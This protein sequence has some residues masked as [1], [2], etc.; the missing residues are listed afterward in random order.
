[1]PLGDKHDMR[2]GILG[3]TF[4]PVHYGHLLMAESC[5]EQLKLEQVWFMPAAVPPH[6][7]Q[8]DVTPAAQRI[9]MLELAIGG[10]GAF[11]VCPYE[12]EKGS[13]SYTV[14]TLSYLV[15]EDPSREIFFILGADSLRDLPSWRQPERICHLAV[16]AV[17]SRSLPGTVDTGEELDFGPLAR[18]VS[19][20]R[21]DTIRSHQVRMPR[22]DLSSSDIR[23]RVA[24]ARSI[25]YQTPRAVEKY[26]DAERLY[27]G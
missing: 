5:R 1:M 15:E 13:V 3:G 17:V 7:Q 18:L 8:A 25:R 11:R 2:L 20:E 14:D 16:P 24:A 6:K 19:P 27:R 23:R 4:D 22:M 26:I 9:A 12:V 21:L 10:H